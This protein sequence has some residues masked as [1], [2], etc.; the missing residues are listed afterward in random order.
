M[1]GLQERMKQLEDALNTNTRVF[2][3]SIQML[4]ILG[5]VTR[6]VVQD[7]FE[8]RA[9]YVSDGKWED[10]TAADGTGRLRPGM[11][12]VNDTGE[13]ETHFTRIDFDSYLKEHLDALT[14]L[15]AKKEEAPPEALLV[16]PEEDSPIIFGGSP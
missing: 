4:E 15:E 1:S 16:S 9:R 14:A 13:R 2:H 6:K 12:V 8:G 7:I 10:H 11:T 3:Q 5:A